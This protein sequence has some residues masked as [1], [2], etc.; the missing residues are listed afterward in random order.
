MLR[1]RGREYSRSFHTMSSTEYSSDG[2]N[3]RVN[4]SQCNCLICGDKAT[5]KHYGAFSCDGCKGFFRR[6]IRKNHVYNC[7]FHRNCTVDKD[8]R[9]Q[10]RYCRLMKCFK[11]GMKKETVQNE[12]DRISSRNGNE[13][14]Q[15]GY[16]LSVKVLLKADYI[17]RNSA[18][19]EEVFYDYDI[20]HMQI[21]TINDVCDSMKQQ[22]LHMVQWAKYIPAFSELQLDDQVALLRAHA[23]EHLLL[24][25]AK[26]SLQ[27]QDILL[28]GNNR[29]IP[30]YSAENS[31][32]TPELDISR[33]GARVLDELVMPLH[34]VHIDDTEYACLKAI[35]FFDPNARGLRDKEKIKGFRKEISINLEKYIRDRYYHCRGRGSDLLL[36]IPALQSITSQ[37]IEQIQ[38]AKLFGVAKIDSL[39]QEMLLG[40][41]V[42]ND[43]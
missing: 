22:L 6:S 4:M 38:F 2:E 19:S 18:I 34:E 29:V 20:S 17:T 16:N 27:L 41:V 7:R 3:M 32:L 28:L 12:R 39:L 11:A 21:A 42:S 35:I 31:G 10:C 24:G 9:N 15:N 23:G 14:G 26:R 30:R 33:V 25:L 40:D 1:Y 43:K 37:M 5:G 36:T 8:K 13:D